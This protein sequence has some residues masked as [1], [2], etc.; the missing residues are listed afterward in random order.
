[1]FTIM[2]ISTSFSGK[3]ITSDIKPNGHAAF[4]LFVLL[5]DFLTMSLTTKLGTT[6]TVEAWDQLQKI[7]KYLQH[8]HN[9][10]FIT[11]KFSLHLEALSSCDNFT[12]IT[13]LQL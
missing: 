4:P 2:S 5:I 6:L 12:M 8:I 13:N 10:L 1:M 3:L 9:I 11:S 7:Q